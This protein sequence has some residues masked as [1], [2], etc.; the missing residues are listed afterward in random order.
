MPPN[1]LVLD[2]NSVL[3]PK[4]VRKTKAQ[5]FM[6]VCSV[7]VVSLLAAWAK[8]CSS[9]M[10]KRRKAD[11]VCYCIRCASAGTMVV[12][13]L[14]GVHN[15]WREPT[16]FRPER[17]MPGGEYDQFDESVKPYMFVPFI[18]VGILQLLDRNHPLW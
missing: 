6:T 2:I 12:C 17:F 4:Q 18:Q 7:P 9:A 16:E 10:N 15:Q 14:Q 8:L 11:R 3:V 1:Q 13:H 5:G